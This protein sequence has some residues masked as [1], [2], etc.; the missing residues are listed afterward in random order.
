MTLLDRY[1]ESILISATD[2]EYGLFY[3][4]QFINS[5][6]GLPDL[7]GFQLSTGNQRQLG[8]ASRV[9]KISGFSSSSKDALLKAYYEGLERTALAFCNPNSIVKQKSYLDIIKQAYTPHPSSWALCADWQYS[10]KDF[11]LIPFK[12]DALFDWVPVKNAHD[13]NKKTLIPYSLAHYAFPHDKRIYLATTNGAA[14][15]WSYEQACSSALLELIERDSFLIHWR[16]KLPGR[17]ILIEH[18]QNPLLKKLWENL[19]GKYEQIH[20]LLFQNEFNVPVIGSLFLERNHDK[21]PISYL[22][23][24][25]AYDLERAIY[26]SLL[27]MIQGVSGL[28]PL[29]SSKNRRSSADDLD[30]SIL[31][32]P[33][34]AQYYLIE[35]NIKKLSFLFSE[36]IQL[37]FRELKEGFSQPLNLPILINKIKDLGY[38]LMFKDYLTPELHR[39]GGFVVRAFCP[40][41][42]PLDYWHKVR[43]IGSKRILKTFEESNLNHS[44]DLHK[45][46]NPYPHPLT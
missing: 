23:L 4:G 34:H 36:N 2:S 8:S 46:L 19:K 26:K 12:E 5:S 3:P 37:P 27:E 9:S 25:S 30:D 33:D 41:L 31:N 42:V 43:A 44:D 20:I 28:G 40:P 15:G 24:A 17:K 16:C 7:C 10:Q 6:L 11:P 29:L 18:V 35:E 1:R 22:G 32:F 14:F 13:E 21:E 38:D 45:K 39:L